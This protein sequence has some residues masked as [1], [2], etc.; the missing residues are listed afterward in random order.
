MYKNAPRTRPEPRM[1][2]EGN[3]PSSPKLMNAHQADQRAMV[4]EGREQSEQIKRSKV[5]VLPGRDGVSTLY[6]QLGKNGTKKLSILF[7]EASK[8]CVKWVICLCG[9]K[10]FLLNLLHARRLQRLYWLTARDG[11][12]SVL[13]Q[14]SLGPA[15]IIEPMF[16]TTRLAPCQD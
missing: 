6:P 9:V 15:T 2:V 13:S 12:R 8:M 7:L 10:K 16:P 3:D 1:T 14:A 11:C 4:E 5:A